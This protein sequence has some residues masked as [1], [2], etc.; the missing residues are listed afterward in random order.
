VTPDQA[1]ALAEELRHHADRLTADLETMDPDEAGAA[2]TTLHWLADLRAAIAAED[3]AAIAEL[4][5]QG[6]A[7][8]M[9]LHPERRDLN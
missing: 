7:A 8:A 9:L 4:L 3:H 5:R 1:R 6:E 2:Q